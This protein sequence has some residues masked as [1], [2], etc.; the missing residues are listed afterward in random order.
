EETIIL[1]LLNGVDSREL[2]QSIFPRN[3]VLD[4]CVYLVAR[5][6]EPGIVMETGNISK[7]FFG[8]A[9]NSDQRLNNFLSVFKE[10]GI[11]ATL[12]PYIEQVIWEKFSFISPI[13]TLTSF[14][15]CSIGEIVADQAK[16]EFLCLLLSELTS[17]SRENGILLPADIY[18]VTIDRMAKLPVDSTS[19]MHSDFKKG[20][21]TEL[22]SLTG[23][24]IRQ[25]ALNDLSV[26]MYTMMYESLRNR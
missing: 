20:N 5:L 12:T 1:P 2:I 21:R 9:N 11:D 17:V 8:S 10:A 13:A 14:L 18:Q 22:E 19:S 15:D 4:G 3:F 23:Y 26:P 16:K 6:T 24:I 7:L 25:A